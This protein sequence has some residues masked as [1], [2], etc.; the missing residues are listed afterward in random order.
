MRSL[1]SC[2][3]WVV[4]GLHVLRAIASEFCEPG[5]PC[6]AQ[7]GTTS[8]NNSEIM[9]TAVGC[10]RTVDVRFV[11]FE[12]NASIAVAMCEFDAN[13]VCVFRPGV[14]L[15]NFQRQCCQTPFQSRE[16]RCSARG[17]EHAPLSIFQCIQ[18]S[19]THHQHGHITAHLTFFA[20]HQADLSNGGQAQVRAPSS[21]H[22]ASP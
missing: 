13:G 20:P 6:V 10:T 2:I 22:P 14:V 7:R 11:P 8:F 21:L 4:A 12:G 17:Q 18:L 19:Y 3:V 5:Y 16:A 15:D 1:Q 9:L